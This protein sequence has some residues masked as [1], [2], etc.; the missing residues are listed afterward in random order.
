MVSL[1]EAWSRTRFLQDSAC[2][3]IQLERICIIKSH[4]V[5]LVHMAFQVFF[6]S[7]TLDARLY[8]SKYRNTLHIW[9]SFHPNIPTDVKEMQLLCA[10]L[11]N[12][13]SMAPRM[14][15]F[16]LLLASLYGYCT[17]PEKE[18]VQPEH[19]GCKHS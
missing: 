11:V 12:S 2:T 8:L 10:P 19:L 1:L 5:L 16:F 14:A 15:E 9:N 17:W 3:H 6:C 13:T 18:S 4:T 7:K